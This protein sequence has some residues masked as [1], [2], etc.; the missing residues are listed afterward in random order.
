MLATLAALLVANI[1]TFSDDVDDYVT[2]STI[3]CD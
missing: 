2:E 3:C 1:R